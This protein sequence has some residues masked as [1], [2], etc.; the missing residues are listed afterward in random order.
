MFKSVSEDTAVAFDEMGFN[1]EDVNT[2][3][4]NLA[5]GGLRDALSIVD[6]LSKNEEKITTDLV[7][8]EIGS[9]SNQKIMDLMLLFLIRLDV[10]RLILI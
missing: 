4:A 3:F 10:C 1:M 7:V 2:I 6:Q 8:R 5:D 9:I